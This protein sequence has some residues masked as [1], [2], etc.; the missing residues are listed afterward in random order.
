MPLGQLLALEQSQ[1]A[2]AVGQIRL[3]RAYEEVLAPFGIKTAQILVTLEDSSNR[4]RYLNSRA[5][6]ETLL[7]LGVV[8]IVNENDTVA[9][10]E[11]RFGDNDRLAARV[12][13][14]IDA[15]LLILL[16]DVDGLYSENP[17]QNKKTKKIKEVFKIDSTIELYYKV[18]IISPIN[19]ISKSMHNKNTHF[20]DNMSY[21]DIY[22]LINNI[23]Y[24]QDDNL[25]KLIS[26]S[27]FESRINK[28]FNL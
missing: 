25:D 6:M 17:S 16:S 20:I 18:P 8:P 21:D 2:A 7:A 1:A 22:T 19:Q 4:R 5:T 23:K 14:M 24:E 28:I 3:A 27:K 10:D 9:T 26:A 13:Q 12:A 15:N 11:I